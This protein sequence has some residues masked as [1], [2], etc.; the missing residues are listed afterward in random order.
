MVIS[1]S[2]NGYLETKLA[3]ILRKNVMSSYK[4]RKNEREMKIKENQKNTYAE[5][6][7]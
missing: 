7:I 6:E 2:A 5:G 4:T 3:T 1:G